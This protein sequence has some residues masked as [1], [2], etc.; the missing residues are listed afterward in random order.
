MVHAR[1]GRLF[2]G[3]VLDVSVAIVIVAASTD[4]EQRAPVQHRRPDRLDGGLSADDGEKRDS[5]IWGD[6]RGRDPDRHSFSVLD[7]EHF[8]PP[9]VSRSTHRSAARVWQAVA[10]ACESNM[11]TVN[12]VGTW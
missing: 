2:Q 1:R 7:R 5:L 6:G 9:C 8:A 4:V 3:H 12:R 11:E 10:L